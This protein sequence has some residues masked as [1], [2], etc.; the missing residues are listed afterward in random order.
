MS[1]ALQN[2]L[3]VDQGLQVL[4]KGLFNKPLCGHFNNLKQHGCIIY[5]IHPVHKVPCTNYR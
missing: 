4:N 2:R 1:G 5:P 3:G